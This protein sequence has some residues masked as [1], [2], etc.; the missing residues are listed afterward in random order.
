VFVIL[1]A[2]ERA[3]FF[4]RALRELPMT[5]GESVDTAGSALVTSGDVLDDVFMLHGSCS[6]AKMA[7][8]PARA[9]T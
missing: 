8:E 7:S 5:V 1:L 6:G 4:A 3:Q 2:F 9:K